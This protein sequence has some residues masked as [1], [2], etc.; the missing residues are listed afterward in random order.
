MTFH[1]IE[2][3]TLH[4]EDGPREVVDFLS[5]SVAHFER[6]LGVA[7]RQL[8]H[9]RA[10]FD[11]LHLEIE[12][13]R[14]DADQWT[15]IVNRASRYTGSHTAQ[16]KLIEKCRGLAALKRLAEALEGEI[17]RIE[18]KLR[19]D[20]AILLELQKKLREQEGLPIP[21]A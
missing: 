21:I 2:Q 3:M 17:S 8:R 20:S 5:E 7:H 6:K 1:A 19:E 4:T 15:E 12:R 9:K 11:A 10:R 16:R 14:E 18:E 13:L